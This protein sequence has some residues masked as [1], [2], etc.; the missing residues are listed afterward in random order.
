MPIFSLD[1]ELV[2]PPA[3]LA[4]PDGLLAIGGDLSVERLLLAYRSGIFPWY[5]GEHIIWWSP[6]PRFI[7]DP[8]NLYISKSMQVFNR[9]TSLLFTI[10]K[11][12]RGVI[13]SCKNSVRRE[14]DGTW[15][16]DEMIAAYTKLHELGFAHSA[17]AWRDDELVAGLY[18][19]RM[20]QFFFGESM[21]TNLSNASKFTFIRYVQQLKSE[22][23]MLIDCQVYT[24]HLESLGASMMSRKEFI[25]ILN[26]NLEPR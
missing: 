23:V 6:D 10:N 18:G 13:E 11:D 20:G 8:D 16:S 24:E 9:K 4:E 3:E 15:I 17:E 2:F 22:G 25:N 7:L 14:Q 21:F 5:E 19:I 26:Q 1:K 12:F